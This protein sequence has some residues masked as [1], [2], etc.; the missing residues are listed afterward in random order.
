MSLLLE[1]P[2]L[3]ASHRYFLALLLRLRRFANRWVANML[4]SRE[5]QARRL[6]LQMLAERK[7]LHR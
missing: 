6:M 5:R 4:A 3:P 2:A 7:L 1:A